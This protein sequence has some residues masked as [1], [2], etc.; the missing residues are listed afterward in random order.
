M[1]AYIDAEFNAYNKAFF[2]ASNRVIKGWIIANNGGLE[3]KV[4]QSADSMLINSERAGFEGINYRPTTADALT[5]TLAD[6]ATNYVEVKIATITCAEDSVA[7]WDQSANSN[8]GEE[9]SQTVD[10]AYEEAPTLVSNTITFTGDADKLPLAIV[11]T[12]GGVITLITDAR[13]LFFQSNA[14]WDFGSPR[15]DRTITSMEEN[16]DALKT[17]IMEI[18]GTAAWF[19]APVGSLYGAFN[20]FFSM[21]VPFT[22]TAKI[23]WSGSA[24]TLTDSNG[25]PANADVLA[26]IR[27][28]GQSQELSLTRED[29]TGGSSTITIADGELVY[30]DIPASGGRIYSNTGSGSTNYKIATRAAF[31]QSD[32]NYWLAYRE[33]TKLYVRGNGEL[34]TGESAEIG[35]NVPATLLTNLGLADE[36]T[37]PSYSSSIR[38]TAAQSLVARL[39]VLTDAEGD[40]QEDRSAYFRSD[41]PVVWSGTSLT[42]TQNIIL[43]IVNTKS[44]TL[45][46]HTILVAGSPIS[47]S[48][49]SSAYISVSR[50]TASENVS[51]VLSSVTPIPAQTQSNKDIFVLARRVGSRLHIPLHKE[52]LNSGQSLRLGNAGESVTITD[53][54]TTNATMYPTWVTTASGS[55]SMKV[56]STKLSFNPSTGSVTA[57]TFVGGLTGVASGN[58][59]ATPNQY[60]VLLSGPANTA[61]VLAPDASLTKVLTSGG[62][63]ANPIW[64]EAIGTPTGSII[65]TALRTAPAGWLMT[66]GSAVSRATYSTLFAAMN[67][68]L[69]TFTV[70]T[71]SPGVFT[72][73][74]HGLQTGELIQ[75][76]NSGGSLPTG[77]TALTDYYVTILT[78]NTFKVSTSM[79][80]VVAGTFVNVTGAGSGTNSVQFFSYG[81]GDGTT[82]FNVPDLRGRV[83]AG[84]DAMGGTA[85]SRLTTLKTGVSGGTSSGFGPALAN[86]G[87]REDHQLTTAQ[88]AAHSHSMTTYQGTNTIPF[89]GR[90]DG[91]NVPN[92]QSVNS[93]GGDVA[94]NNVQP[95][96]I[97]NYIIKT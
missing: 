81:S 25:G 92:S 63:S 65:A 48:D 74:A 79:A 60:G 43:E 7:I 53:D 17:A 22:T 36:A 61:T 90:G 80:N 29:G 62:A 52:V 95:T 35:D 1:L 12:A 5:L 15:S 55:Q 87:G 57:P 69:G 56:S 3:V 24:M 31:V 93:T 13:D 28:F 40:G 42:F 51:V 54:T 77:L 9:F 86:T 94:H 2:G 66:D 26:K 85:A 4:S 49:G 41:D 30:V 67:P 11:T 14:D 16:D 89:F 37:A 45:T 34:Q 18:K 23:S 76:S 19:T 82:T 88:L 8:L 97:V 21:I 10:T 32:A 72:I 91:V 38:G 78:A 33:G 96:L 59:Q 73:T 58:L 6:N 68:S 47:L 50:T 44:G 75:L 83:I 46:Q 84:A 27:I 39:G 70:T 64:S 20:N 71:A